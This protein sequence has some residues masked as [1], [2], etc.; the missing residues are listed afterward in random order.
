MS[1]FDLASVSRLQ[2]RDGGLTK[3]GLHRNGF[4]EKRKDGAVWVWQRPALNSGVAAPVTGSGM[5]LYLVGTTLWGVYSTS[6]TATGAAAVAT[7]GRVTIPYGGTTT[8]AVSITGPGTNVDVY[9]QTLLQWPDAAS[10]VIRYAVT[11]TGEVAKLTWDS[12]GSFPASCVFN[13][14]NL[15]TIFGLGGTGGKGGST[16]ANTSFPGAAGADALNLNGKTVS[17]NN[18]SGNIW[19]GG[20]GGGGGGAGGLAGGSD[21]VGGGGG[22]GAGNGVGGA[23]GN[24]GAGFPTPAT[25]GTSGNMTTFGVGGGGSANPGPP[26]GGTGGDGGAFAADGTIGGA[27]GGVSN[28]PP[29]AGGAAGKAIALSGGAANFTSGA[30][31]PNVKGAIS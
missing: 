11:V 28:A 5:G 25:A 6:G 9:T 23:F 7:S 24:G 17:I 21:T 22:G 31:S 1:R 15:G 12:A 29:G 19:G 20:G 3:G 14:I 4:V 10:K 27:A 13:L 16:D 26:V 18:G 30:S 8:R 2:S